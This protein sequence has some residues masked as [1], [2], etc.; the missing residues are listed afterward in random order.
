MKQGDLLAG[1]PHTT[2]RR[3]SPF[4]GICPLLL[5]LILCG[6]PVS[7]RSP[8]ASIS[9]KWD[10]CAR[11]RS[12]SSTWKFTSCQSVERRGFVKHAP[13]DHSPKSDLKAF[14]L[15]HVTFCNS[16]E[17]SEIMNWVDGQKYSR[18]ATQPSNDTLLLPN[19][20]S[21]L[22]P[23]Q[24]KNEGIEFIHREVATSTDSQPLCSGACPNSSTSMSYPKGQKKFI[25]SM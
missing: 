4:K 18:L 23:R 10:S 7:E 22:A 9:Y 11:V 21:D 2:L 19:A 5:W 14:K 3:L 24:G 20:A 12:L 17:N 25:V 13:L 15:K 16:E 8:I 6:L 1:Q